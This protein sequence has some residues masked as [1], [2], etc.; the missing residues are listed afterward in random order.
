MRAAG[1]A[2]QE[3]GFDPAKA[4]GFRSSPLTAR[5]C[6]SDGRRRRAPRPQRRLLGGGRAGLDPARRPARRIGR[7]ARRRRAG[8]ARAAAGRA[9]RSTS[10]AAAAAPRPS[11]R[12][13]ACGAAV[14]VDLSPA[15]VAAAGARFPRHLTGSSPPT[16]RRP[17]RA[18]CPVRRRLLADVP[19]A[20]GR[21]GRR[22]RDGI[23]RSLRPGGRFAATVFRDGAANPWLYAAVLGAAPHVGALPPLP[24]GD[25]P[26]P[27]AFADAA[28]VSRVLTAAGFTDVAVEPHDV[29]LDC[30]PTIRTR[31]PT[32]SSSTARPERRTAPRRRTTGRPPARV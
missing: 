15:M 25:E 22:L 16:S 6:R 10:A 4:A 28:R 30:G 29:V 13:S 19:D 3:E 31:W 8:G 11:W 26:G 7:P 27:F 18:R 14:G 9:G 21:S 23:R 2:A 17:R 5:R 32:G 1:L 24:V 20:A 12:R